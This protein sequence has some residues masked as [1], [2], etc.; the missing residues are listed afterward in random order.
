M[1]EE[2]IAV[3]LH[4]RTLTNQAR[5]EMKTE[6]K[7]FLHSMIDE[8]EEALA[9]ILNL[10]KQYGDHFY[11]EVAANPVAVF[12]E[13]NML[14][15]EYQRLAEI[16]KTRREAVESCLQKAQL[17]IATTREGKL[18][19]I[20]AQ[21]AAIEQQRARLTRKLGKAGGVEEKGQT[22]A[23]I[24]AEISTSQ[25]APTAATANEPASAAP[26][27]KP[28]S[29]EEEFLS[30]SD[31]VVPLGESLTK[32]PEFPK[33]GEQMT[34]AEIVEHYASILRKE[35]MLH[36]IV[37]L[38]SKYPEYIQEDGGKDK[39]YSIEFVQIIHSLIE[40]WTDISQ[41][42]KISHVAKSFD[43][44]VG[45]LEPLIEPLLQ[46][47]PEYKRKVSY[48]A[49][50]HGSGSG[51]FIILSPAAVIEI[52]KMPFAEEKRQVEAEQSKPKR[53]KAEMGVNIRSLGHLKMFITNIKDL[54]DENY[55]VISL[56]D[57]NFK[58][59]NDQCEWDIT[60]DQIGGFFFQNP[61]PGKQETK[62]IIGQLF[63]INLQNPVHL[64]LLIESPHTLRDAQGNWKSL[65]EIQF[66]N[67]W[68]VSTQRIKKELVPKYTK[69][70]P[71]EDTEWTIELS[72]GLWPDWTRALIK[73]DTEKKTVAG[74]IPPIAPIG[75]TGEEP[76]AAQDTHGNLVP[77]DFTL[78]TGEQ[79]RS[80]IDSL[81]EGGNREI[82][83]LPKTP[84]LPNFE[85]IADQEERGAVVP[86]NAQQALQSLRTLVPEL[87]FRGL[88]AEEAV[89]LQRYVEKK[90]G[91]SRDQIAMD[92]CD[93][94]SDLLKAAASY[95]ADTI[96]AN[97][98]RIAE[99]IQRAQRKGETYTPRQDTLNALSAYVLGTTKNLIRNIPLVDP[100]GML[101]RTLDNGDIPESL[102]PLAILALQKMQQDVVAARMRELIPT[103][104]PA[105]R[106]LISFHAELILKLDQQG[107]HLADFVGVEGKTDMSSQIDFLRSVDGYTDVFG[108]L[109]EK[110]VP[111]T[112]AT[113]QE[114]K[115]IMQLF[116]E[117]N[118]ELLEIAMA[119]YQ[120]EKRNAV[121]ATT[122]VNLKLNDQH[123]TRTGWKVSRWGNTRRFH[124]LNK[125]SKTL[126]KKPHHKSDNDCFQ[127]QECQQSI[128][129]YLALSPS[130]RVLVKDTLI[131]D[132]TKNA[133]NEA[134][135]V[136]RVVE[137]FFAIVELYI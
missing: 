26:E 25:P 2:K 65:A 48:D 83:I 20:E 27:A 56:S 47:H 30:I 99:Q 58:G 77:I 95:M 122:E 114:Y 40:K 50:G 124:I 102:S 42:G 53:V 104:I 5:K 60:G 115:G 91:Q 136:K 132:M 118:S 49:R 84:Q 52:K 4:E 19:A 37:I 82:S 86:Q 134:G 46:Q 76:G 110:Q 6:V 72:F 43:M 59:A 70:K 51:H 55:E 29:E 101:R 3:R 78:P 90:L 126:L 34:R 119:P 100:S 98:S 24:P 11:K 18:Q 67:I 125:I 96:P 62:K 108:K 10:R 44:N 31:V 109:S 111:T 63:P 16:I 38:Q 61:F 112:L 130:E 80:L 129:E 128:E 57:K 131:K 88:R 113:F 87:S 17:T 94:A 8:N 41:W 35:T 28:L 81:L 45:E 36:L 12:G 74:P 116:L 33:G 85:T 9:H 93:F 7:A 107:K 66:N 32:M 15:P 68:E 97:I 105:Y 117:N 137:T 121:F 123:N 89:A 22:P 120:R 92:L 64:R 1:S 135:A 23:P 14:K 127:F 71:F 21:L 75:P 103:L 13:E 69:E 54:L 133:A 73:A 79:P 39:V 106:E